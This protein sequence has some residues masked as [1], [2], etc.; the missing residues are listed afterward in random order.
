MQFADAALAAEGDLRTR[1]MNL[2]EKEQNDGIEIV[3]RADD[4]ARRGQ[5]LGFLAV[6]LVMVLAGYVASLGQASW[7]AAIAG[8]D[9]VG[10]AGVF[11]T[12]QVVTRKTATGDSG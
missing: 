1:L 7:A 12:G 4:T 6:L 2:A 5:H 11:V 3:R 9:V 10:V 8:I